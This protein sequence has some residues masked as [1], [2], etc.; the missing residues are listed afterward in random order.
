MRSEELT[1]PQMAKV[2]AELVE[3]WDDLASYF[4]GQRESAPVELRSVPSLDV[5]IF[6][7]RLSRPQFAILSWLLSTGKFGLYEVKLSLLSVCL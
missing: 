4:G 5:Q 3:R 1:L 6:N 7:D 2:C